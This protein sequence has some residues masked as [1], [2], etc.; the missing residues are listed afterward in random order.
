MDWKRLAGVTGGIGLF[1]A[2]VAGG[3]AALVGLLPKESPIALPDR[4]LLMESPSGP[5]PIEAPPAARRLPP[6]AALPP[7]VR[8]PAP[9]PVSQPIAE[10]NSP[11]PVP[12][13]APPAL[14]A[15]EAPARPE[16]PGRAVASLAPAPERRSARPPVV[17]V[18]PPAAAPPDPVRRA[19]APPEPRQDGVLT[20][21]EIRRIRLS[22]RLTRDQEPYWLPVEQLLRDIGAQ[23]A[24]MVRAGQDPKDAFGTGAAMRMYSAA[25]P[26][27]DVMRED[28]KAQVRA[29]A[30]AMGF[31]SIAS[32]L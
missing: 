32:S 18:T 10:P 29:R 30:Q 21:T 28:Q 12:P 26:L 1:A 27:L 7:P 11:A 3:S 2:V 13:D 15:A 22:L 14:E 4:A 6:Q 31:G 9:P 8:A 23:Q 19:L 17:A 5:R 16:R 24:A 20:A 25:R